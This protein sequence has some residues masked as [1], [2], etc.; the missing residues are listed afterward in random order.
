MSIISFS[1]LFSF[2]SQTIDFPTISNFVKRLPSLEDCQ[3]LL[4][5]SDISCSVLN[6]STKTQMHD[7]AIFPAT[8]SHD[9]NHAY[10]L[11]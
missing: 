9:A 8:R 1:Y 2:S 5:A 4:V 10:G 7:V 6:I 3:I 11:I